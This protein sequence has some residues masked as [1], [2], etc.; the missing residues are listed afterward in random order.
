MYCFGT[1]ALSQLVLGNEAQSELDWID[2]PSFLL[3]RLMCFGIFFW[4]LS[5]GG[6]CICGY[7][8]EREGMGEKVIWRKSTKLN[9][10]FFYISYTLQTVFL[11]AIGKPIKISYLGL[12]AN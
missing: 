4:S 12:I 1:E 8:K 2:R 6:E 5:Q 11:L 3:S 10:I 9:A 7:D